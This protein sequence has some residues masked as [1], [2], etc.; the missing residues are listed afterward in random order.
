MRSKLRIVAIGLLLP[1]MATA[2]APELESAHAAY[3]AGKF[4]Q[5]VEQYERAGASR[6]DVTATAEL[7]RSYQIT[8]QPERAE[9]LANAVLRQ[10][11]KNTEALLVLGDVLAARGDWHA[12]AERFVAATTSDSPQ[13]EI[14]LRLG[15][16][17]QA[18]GKADLADMAF[19]AYRQF[20]EKP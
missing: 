3:G 10:S 4:Y 6:R 9:A 17:L 8:R 7:A 16:A 20:K 5:A 2:G 13:P 12:A 14:W 1:L 18:E 19:S 15:Q 11:P